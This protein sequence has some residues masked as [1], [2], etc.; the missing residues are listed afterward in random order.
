MLTINLIEALPRTALYERLARENRIVEEPG[1]ESN[2]VFRR[3]Y[4]EV[5][6]PGSGASRKPMSP[7]RSTA[8]FAYNCEHTIPIASKPDFGPERAS[9]SNIA[10]GH[11]HHEKPVFARRR[12]VGLP[13]DLLETG[14]CRFCA[15]AASRI[16]SILALSGITWSNS[17]ARRCRAAKRV[18]LRAQYPVEGRQRRRK[19]NS[20]VFRLG[21]DGSRRLERNVPLELHAGE[22]YVPPLAKDHEK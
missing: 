2:V 12:D 13:A 6:H 9:W 18:L 14:A 21:N 22:R 5:V 17:R 1:R 3:P 11:A 7:A 20:S 16:S 15:R 8:R 10:Y 19:V 4:D